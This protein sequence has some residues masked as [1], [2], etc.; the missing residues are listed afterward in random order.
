MRKHFDIVC[1]SLTSLPEIMQ[2]MVIICEKMSGPREK[3]KKKKK[4]KHTSFRTIILGP[5]NYL[6][7]FNRYRQETK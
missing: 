1:M 2:Q 4:K 3:S 7:M 6:R 5:Q